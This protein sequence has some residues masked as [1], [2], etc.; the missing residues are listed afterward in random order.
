VKVGLSG[1]SSTNQP[2]EH[3]GAVV[4]WRMTGLTTGRTASVGIEFLVLDD[5]RRIVSDH[6]FILANP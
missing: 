5:D 6:Q 4:Q 2:I 1:S 3:H